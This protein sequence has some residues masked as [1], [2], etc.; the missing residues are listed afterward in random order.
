MTTKEQEKKALEQIKKIV[1]GLGQDSYLATAFEGAFEDAEYNIRDDAAY[2][3]KARWDSAKQ[4]ADE[5]SA[6][7]DH[8]IGVKN[9]LEKKLEEAEEKAKKEWENA[10]DYAMESK[11]KDKQ[12]AELQAKLESQKA[13]FN[14]AIADKDNLLAQRDFE[15]M[16]LKAK[17]YDLMNQ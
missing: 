17:L 12:I 2:S 4:K 11:E 9:H 16:Q 10:H 7:Y 1:D 14:E 3:M 15:V 13:E 5:L 6:K 8:L